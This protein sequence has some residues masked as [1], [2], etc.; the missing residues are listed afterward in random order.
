MVAEAVKERLRAQYRTL[1]PVALLA[2]IRAA[3]E[4]LG[5]R[6]DRRAG[7]ALRENAGGKSDMVVHSS[8][9]EPAAFARGLGND[10]ARGEP[11]ATHRRPK[12]R[13]KKRIRMPSKLDPHV[14]LIE[15]WL[16]AE[17]QLT[18]IAIVG[19]LADL[20]P[21]QFGKKQHSIVQRL[22]RAL[23]RSAAQRLIAETA[24]EGYENVAQPPGAVDG[25]GYAGPDPPT[26]PLPVPTFNVDPP[27][28]VLWPPAW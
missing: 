7:G 22:L 21:D 25:S 10:L 5:N 28:G 9:A 2:E 26:A 18:A 13:Y 19:R 14:A 3:Q 1:D 17:P 12:R 20:H 23:R 24:G 16:A 11:R 27:A 8:T 15:G 6:I 4:E